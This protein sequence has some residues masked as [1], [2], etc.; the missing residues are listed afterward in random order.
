MYI[1]DVCFEVFEAYVVYVEFKALGSTFLVLG[2]TKV[3]FCLMVP[4]R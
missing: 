1:S 2:G 4:E 3:L